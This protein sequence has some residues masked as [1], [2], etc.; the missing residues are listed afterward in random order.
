MQKQG[1]FEL[2]QVVM[3]KVNSEKDWEDH[4]SK[5]P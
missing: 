5:K 1:N 2:G 3:L 4:S